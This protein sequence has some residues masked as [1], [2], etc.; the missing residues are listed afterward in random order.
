VAVFFQLVLI[1]INF[2]IMRKLII[3]M[4]VCLVLIVSFGGCSSSKKSYNDRRGLMLL[5]NKEL[6]RNKEYYSRH[7]MKSRKIAQKKFRK[8]R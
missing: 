2:K 8:N 7:N 4:I 5:D 6:S 3:S 1:I